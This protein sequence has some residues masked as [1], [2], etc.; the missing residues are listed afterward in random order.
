MNGRVFLVKEFSVQNLV[1]EVYVVKCEVR[2]DAT[3]P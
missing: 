1:S 3:A 2:F